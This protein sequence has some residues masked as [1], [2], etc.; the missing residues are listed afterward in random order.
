MENSINRA[1][2]KKELCCGLSLEEAIIHARQ[3]AEKKDCDAHTCA[4]Q[5][6]R[7]ADWLEELKHYKASGLEPCDY[8]S[9]RAAYD[10]AEKARA[11]L[12]E[13]V[14]ALGECAPLMK[15]QGA[16]RLHVLP[17][18]PGDPIWWV[19]AGWPNPIAYKVVSF[20]IFDN[21]TFIEASRVPG[22]YRTFN[23]KDVGTSVFLSE[24]AA[25]AALKVGVL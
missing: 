8:A 3:I 4:Y 6:D 1:E 5:H 14:K 23:V 2:T 19:K 12:S 22:T 10:A 16:G 9:V 21:E 7:L 20:N 24:E 15:A 11:D 13:A 17:C 25:L 18:K